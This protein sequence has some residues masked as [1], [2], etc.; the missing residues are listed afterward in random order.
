MAFKI[1]NN[2]VIS[3]NSVL[4]NTTINTTNVLN[5][6]ITVSDNTNSTPMSRGDTI[7]FVGSGSTTVTENN[8]TITIDS[9]GVN[10]GDVEPILDDYF[11]HTNHVN[12][13]A[14]LDSINGEILLSVPT[15]V[16]AFTNDANYA[17]DYSNAT[18]MPEDI[19]GFVAGT[20]FSNISIEDML[21]GILYPY[22]YPA[23]S[24]FGIIGISTQYEVGDTIAAGNYTANWTTTNSSNIN[25]NTVTIVDTTNSTTLLSN[26]SND[27]TEVLALPNP[28]TKAT[29]TSNVWTIS[30]TNTQ[31]GT[32]T[33]NI[34]ANWRWRVY[35]GTSA[36]T[37]LDEAGVEALTGTSLSSNFT[38]NKT[39]AAGDYKWM[40]Y[41]TTMG[42]KTSFFDQATGFGVAMEPA[43]TLAITNAYGITQ[44]Y[45]V[46]RTTN[47]IVG[48]IT[49]GV[50]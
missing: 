13:T 43:Y 28:V 34:T 15:N 6:V 31:S 19:G 44:N 26:S 14:T 36:S 20:T 33:R 25:A 39:F 35:H 22:Q 23:F 42:L 49:I 16:S 27:G 12:I 7:T 48:A 4:Q 11:V 45:Y 3:D 9:S 2:E 1:V 46:H 47:T 5:N 29:A 38:G 32:F 50:S 40:A 8:G 10:S 18:P 41:P 17:V 30:A 24:S 37:V 21:T